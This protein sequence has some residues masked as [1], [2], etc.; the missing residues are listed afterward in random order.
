MKIRLTLLLIVLSLIGIV[1]SVYAYKSYYH[2]PIAILTTA[3]IQAQLVPSR[4]GDARVGGMILLASA[5]KT[6]RNDVYKNRILLLDAGN[7][8][9]G[10]LAHNELS[11]NMP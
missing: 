8:L 2:A 11:R 9:F 10:D 4:E 7:S 3:G 6:Q 5:L 1:W